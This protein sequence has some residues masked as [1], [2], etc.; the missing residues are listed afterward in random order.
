MNLLDSVN[1]S[2]WK[3]PSE[4]LKIDTKMGL[5]ADQ[6]KRFK[7]IKKSKTKIKINKTQIFD[8]ASADTVPVTLCK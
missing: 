5:S 7:K 6:S 2:L 8:V 1:Q 4:Q 3:D